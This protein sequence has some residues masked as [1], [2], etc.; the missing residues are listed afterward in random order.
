MIGVIFEVW[1]K[2]EFKDKYLEL[3]AELRGTLESI[4]GFISVERFQSI[5]EDNKMLSLSFFENQKALDEWRNLAEH[6]VAQRV[7]RSRYF[8][9]YRLRV[10]EVLRDY[11]M[12]QREQA[13]TDSEA[14]LAKK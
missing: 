11:G 2:P 10:V 1:P 12:Q 7:G 9:D 8:Q 14:L 5:S 4:E 13:P 3:A 6:R